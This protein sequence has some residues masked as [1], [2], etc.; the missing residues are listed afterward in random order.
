MKAHRSIVDETIW[1]EVRQKMGSKPKRYWMSENVDK[2]NWAST[3]CR[4]WIGGTL[5]SA[6]FVAY[7]GNKGMKWT[8][9]DNFHTKTR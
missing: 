5:C 1:Q 2:Q 3:S 9:K 6:K 8:K 4:Q 7:I